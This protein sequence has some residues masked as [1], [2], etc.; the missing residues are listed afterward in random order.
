MFWYF[1]LLA[2]DAVLLPQ[3][4]LRRESSEFGPMVRDPCYV[5]SAGAR[6]VCVPVPCVPARPALAIPLPAAVV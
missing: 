3:E 6:W 2:A 4:L 1:V 5:L